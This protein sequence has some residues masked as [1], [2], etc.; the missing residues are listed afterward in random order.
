[1]DLEKININ[2]LDIILDYRKNLRICYIVLVSKVGSRH[3]EILGI[4]HFLEHN[5]FK[6]SKKYNYYQINEFFEVYGGSI[7]ATTSEEN[8]IIFTTVIKE[9]LFSALDILFDIIRNPTFEN[10]ELEKNV[11]LQEYNEFINDSEELSYYY[12]NKA[13]FKNHPLGRNIL[14]NPKTIKNFTL[15]DLRRRKEEVFSKDN[16]I[17]MISGDFQKDELLDFINDNVLLEKK[18]EIKANPF[19]NYKP[20]IKERIKFN[21]HCYVN[22][23]IPIFDYKNFILE[24]LIISSYLGDGSSSLLFDTIRE[25]KGLVYDIHTFL[26]FYDE[27]CVFG[28][29][30]SIDCKDFEKV[31]REIERILK[32]LEFKGKDFEKTKQKFKTKTLIELEHRP[33]YLS[34]ILSE[35]LFRGKIITLEEFINELENLNENNFP[36]IID[37]IRNFDN[38]SISVVG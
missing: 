36:K 26:D 20:S 31:L 10:Y 34:F 14:G 25:K 13:I 27:V 15:E 9:K 17:L 4:T 30:Y 28:I 29:N 5:I 38:Y 3:E 24:L 33:N 22:L 2:N 16:V 1:M 19:K 37:I 12:L 23:G 8:V 35:Y 21:N 11:I 7:D 32:N 18:Y 6:G